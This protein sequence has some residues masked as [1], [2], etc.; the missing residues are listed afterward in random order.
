VA[1]EGRIMVEGRKICS[2]DGC[3]R[4]AIARGWCDRCYQ[5]WRKH[6]DPAYEKPKPT[7]LVDGC[8]SAAR[9]RG[10]C[11]LHYNIWRREGGLEQPCLVGDCNDA[12]IARGW[13]ARHYQAWQRH[14]DPTTRL[15]T[16]EAQRAG[17]WI[18][19][20]TDFDRGWVIGIFDGEGNVTYTSNDV[21]RYRG[22]I[23]VSIINTDMEMLER[24]R[25]V[26]GTGNISP[27]KRQMSHHLPCWYWHVAGPPAI[28][29]MWDWYPELSEKRRRQFLWALERWSFV[30]D[31]G[32][33]ARAL[34]REYCINGHP[35]A[36]ETTYRSPNGGH[37]QCAL[38]REDQAAR[39]G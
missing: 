39:A 15:S 11:A 9:K 13:C 36:E 7:C 2:V 5:R 25:R 26:V 29:L 30:K 24:V 16:L 4:P 22:T 17:L 1:A 14:G 33:D 28:R 6:G 10:W 21:R 23:R 18:R 34:K 19:S 31:L 35:W 38:C 3:G 12:A 8:E 27:M 37:K 32:T 20:M